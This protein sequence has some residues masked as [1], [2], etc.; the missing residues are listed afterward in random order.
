MRRHVPANNNNTFIAEQRAL[1]NEVLP[2]LSNGQ[3]EAASM[4]L[5][6]EANPGRVITALWLF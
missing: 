1:G 6:V 2:L 5:R 4:L 3:N